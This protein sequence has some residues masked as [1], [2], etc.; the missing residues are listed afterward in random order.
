M[1]VATIEYRRSLNLDVQALFVDGQAIGDEY[2]VGS[3]LQAI[4]DALTVLE[5][6]FQIVK[7]FQ[8]MNDNGEWVGEAAL[9]D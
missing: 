1:R 8:R 7:T 9:R 3:Q 5:I 6:P 4:R 2:Q